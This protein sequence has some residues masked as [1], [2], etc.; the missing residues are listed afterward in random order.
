MWKCKSEDNIS[1]QHDTMTD[2]MDAI[3]KH[4]TSSFI[5]LSSPQ[6]KNN[7]TQPNDSQDYPLEPF[8]G[9]L[10]GD[11]SVGMSEVNSAEAGHKCLSRVK[12][13]HVTTSINTIF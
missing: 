12:H 10:K 2:T 13:I 7:T 8:I 4:T 3:Y 5:E 6:I 9:Y 11:L 1:Q